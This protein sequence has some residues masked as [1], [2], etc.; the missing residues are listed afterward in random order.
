MKR[1]A[2]AGEPAAQYRLGKLH[3]KGLGVPRD[4]AQARKWTEVSGQWRKHPRDA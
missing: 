1:S 3:E 2:E 4:F